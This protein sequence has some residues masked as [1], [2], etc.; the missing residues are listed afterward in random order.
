ME[1]H[2]EVFNAL[3]EKIS[4]LVAQLEFSKTCSKNYAQEVDNLK[5]KV[6]SQ[7][8]KLSHNQQQVSALEKKNGSLKIKV[9]NLERKLGNITPHWHNPDNL[10]D[11]QIGVA[12][13]WRLL[14]KSEIHDR[15]ETS[16]IQGLTLKGSWDNEPLKGASVVLTY[17]TKQPLGYWR[18]K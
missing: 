6:D 5:K 7:W 3:N 13:G 12:D 14:E 2:A 8:L 9:Q 11:E 17:R 18:D 4:S 1:I 15:E 16:E 10:T